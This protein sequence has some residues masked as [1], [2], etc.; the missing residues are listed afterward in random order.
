M[1]IICS[2]GVISDLQSACFP[3]QDI[4]RRGKTPI[5]VGGNQHFDYCTPFCI[6]HHIIVFC[7]QVMG[8]F[9]VG[10]YMVHL[11]QMCHEIWANEDL[12]KPKLEPL[13]RVEFR[14][15]PTM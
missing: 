12:S 14:Q 3:F 7:F 6:H 13:L 11:K 10:Y 5:V 1:D 4:T 15:N 9:C 2:D 8:S